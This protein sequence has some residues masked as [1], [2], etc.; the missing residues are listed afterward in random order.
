[1]RNGELW[2]RA[3]RQGYVTSDDVVDLLSEADK[4]PEQL[5][6]AVGREMGIIS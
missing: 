6:A 1:M 4:N 5:V 2:D 3:K